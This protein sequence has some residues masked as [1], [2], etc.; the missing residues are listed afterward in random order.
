MKAAA[1]KTEN[2]TTA[3]RGFANIIKANARQAHVQTKLT[4][5][6]PGDKYEQEADQVADQ[7]MS[8]T[9]PQVQRQCMS[10]DEKESAVQTKPLSENITPWI[11]RQVE[12][13]ELQMKSFLQRQTEEEEEEEEEM[14]QPKLQRQEEEE[15]ELQAKN[16]VTA[17]NGKPEVSNN[18]EGRIAQRKGSGKPLNGQVRS[19]MESGFG[20]DFSN[21]RIHNDAEAAQMASGINAQAFTTG[22]D[23]Y[24]NDGKYDPN[25]TSGKNLLAHELTHVVQ[26]NG[27]NAKVSGKPS[28]GVPLGG[29]DYFEDR[30]GMEKSNVRIEEKGGADIQRLGEDAEADPPVPEPDVPGAEETEGGEETGPATPS[31]NL[32][33][34]N[35]LTRGDALTATIGFTAT[36]GETNRITR[37][38]FTTA[39]HGEVLRPT[40]DADFQTQ[41]AGVMAV[42]GTL[43][44]AYRITPSGGEEGEEQTLSEEITV[45]DR[46]GDD[47][48]SEVQQDAE[49]AYAGRPS[50]PV[51]F[52]DLGI[53]NEDITEPALDLDTISGGPNRG[54]RFVENITAGTYISSPK[55]HPDLTNTASPFYTF[56]QHAGLL[57]FVVGDVKTLIPNAEYSN[58]SFAGGSI[59]FEVPN[60]EQF[61]KSHNMMEVV[62]ETTDG[63]K[64]FVVPESAWEL[65]SNAEDSGVNITDEAVVRAGLEIEATDG[66]SIISGLT[67]SWSAKQLLQAPAILAGTRNHEY[68]HNTHSHRANFLKMMR[69]L[70]PEKLIE[71]RVSAPGH[72][73]NHADLLTTWRT[74]ILRPNH[75]I[76]D[77]AASAEQEAFMETGETMA[78][79][80]EDTSGTVLGSVWN[81][82]GD[83]EMTN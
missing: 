83:A 50:P 70:D 1:I 27:S 34:G 52:S 73:L 18:I 71:D 10:C 47:W 67:G 23:V 62:V 7:V 11:Q 64:T 43:E 14:L 26:Q 24:F 65:Q 17:G 21:T 37:W 59:S 74:E 35:T 51:V 2:K 33:P 82:T 12:E 36:A 79:V 46:T 3:S 9:G 76:V 13:E 60:W 55:I 75:E 45:D 4:V 81:I 68:Q 61:Y 28:A 42:S 78:G 19:E 22:H 5:G 49:T 69:A 16:T 72:T 8:M 39:G 54:F 48:E 29:H 38:K 15:E 80:N 53:H 32:V 30:T 20:A 31:L 56:H 58:L 41:W 44:V 66:Y 57:W 25:S 40:S 77:E 6:Q 63:S